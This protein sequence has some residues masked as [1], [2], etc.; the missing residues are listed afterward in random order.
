MSGEHKQ[1]EETSEEKTVDTP[2]LDR[3]ERLANVAASAQQARQWAARKSGLRNDA[4]PSEVRD[5]T[6][7]SDAKAQ[8]E[9]AMRMMMA[10]PNKKTRRW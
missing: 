7:D 9:E 3:L 2:Q 5:L 8:A 6:Q 1:N 4:E 10:K